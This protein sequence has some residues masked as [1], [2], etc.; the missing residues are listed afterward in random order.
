MWTQIYK[1]IKFML[2]AF[3]DEEGS[4]HSK[5][6]YLKEELKKLKKVYDLPVQLS[7]HNTPFLTIQL[8]R[9]KTHIP[10][11]SFLMWTFKDFGTFFSELLAKQCR[12][13]LSEARLSRPVLHMQEHACWVKAPRTLINTAWGLKFV[14]C[15][16]ATHPC[17]GN[18]HNQ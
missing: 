1:A 8:S 18:L 4:N 16:T 6:K 14:Y 17:T 3:T 12:R 15:R 10:N 11:Q 2:R 9:W 13:S 7:V 5:E